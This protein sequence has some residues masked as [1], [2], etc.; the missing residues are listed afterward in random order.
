MS[1]PSGPKNVIITLAPLKER[2]QFIST[3][4]SE[5]SDDEEIDI[6]NIICTRKQTKPAPLDLKAKKKHTRSLDGR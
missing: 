6:N 3:R 1:P 2:P 5:T 4:L